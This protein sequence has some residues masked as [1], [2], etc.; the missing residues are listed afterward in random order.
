M[1]LTNEE[2]NQK[3]KNMQPLNST[4]IPQISIKEIEEREHKRR[5]EQANK[6]PL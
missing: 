4:D 3:I 2:I 6:L 1:V 5:I